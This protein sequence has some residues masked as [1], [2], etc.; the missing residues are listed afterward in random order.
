MKYLSI[1]F[2]FTIS[3]AVCAIEPIVLSPE[4]ASQYGVSVTKQVHEDQN[5]RITYIVQFPDKEL[6]DGVEEPGFAQI[7]IFYSGDGKKSINIPQFGGVAR[8]SSDKE[9]IE[10]AK[11]TINY[12]QSKLKRFLIVPVTDWK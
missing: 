2:I 5:N 8:F 10:L 9:G 4:N 12:G 3:S 7:H 6:F 1:F 11:I